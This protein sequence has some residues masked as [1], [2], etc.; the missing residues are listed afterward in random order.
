MQQPGERHLRAAHPF[1]CRDRL[2]ALRDGRI[3][4]FRSMIKGFAILVR[5]CT[6]RGFAPG[7]RQPAAR[8]RTPRQHGDILR[9]TERVHLALLFALNQIV[10]ILHADEWR[11]AVL[12]LGINRFGELPRIHRR[13]ADIA[14]FA[15]LHHVAQRFQ[16]LLQRRLIIPAV[17]LQQVDILHIQT[18]QAVVDR[19][20]NIFT[21]Q[22]LRQIAEREVNLGGDHNLL[23]TRESL[24]RAADDLFAAAVGIAVCGIE[25]VNAG[26]QRLLDQRTA[27]RFRQR[28]GVATAVRL[29]KS[30][31]AKAETGNLKVGVA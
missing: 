22:A 31:A 8:Q 23:A 18:A 2:D 7:T 9:L 6:R 1:T 19:L 21:R 26:L 10:L 13:G 30:H 28:P 4:L 12:P 16:R 5:G 15:R 14:R 11:P 24:Q 27:A 29:A 17:N 20:H 3:I 25:K